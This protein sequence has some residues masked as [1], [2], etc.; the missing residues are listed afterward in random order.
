MML[1]SIIGI[2]WVQIVW[3]KKAVSIQNEG[4]QQCSEVRVLYN[5]ANSI[6]SSRKM[7][8]FNNFMPVADPFSF[9]DSSSDITGYLSIG[10]YSS[11]Q[12]NKFSLSITNQSV[13][14]FDKGKVTRVNKSY[15][16]N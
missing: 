1:L 15:T 13:T 10:S 16:I 12:D 7:N 3:I 6:E 11:A 5:A 8:F 4:F 2:I 14:G 9:N